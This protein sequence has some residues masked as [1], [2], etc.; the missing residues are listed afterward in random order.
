MGQRT[1]YRRLGNRLTLSPLRCTSWRYLR[2]DCQTRIFYQDDPTDRRGCG[3]EQPCVLRKLAR[4]DVRLGRTGR[5]LHCVCKAHWVST[6]ADAKLRKSNGQ[7]T[8]RT[9]EIEQL[10]ETDRVAT[11]VDAKRKHG[12][13]RLALNCRRNAK[14]G[15]QFV[16]STT[17]EGYRFRTRRGTIPFGSSHS[18]HRYPLHSTADR[19]CRLLEGARWKN[20]RREANPP[21]ACDDAPT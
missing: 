13:S 19:L 7:R 8:H 12:L 1:L 4:G 10:S 20:S 9:D 6:S 21:S 2:G 11:R 3:R 14:C 5:R 15:S 17:N 18:S 16:G